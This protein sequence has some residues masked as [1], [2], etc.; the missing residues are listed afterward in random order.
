M[1][2][3]LLVSEVLTRV[4]NASSDDER[5]K[6]LKDFETHALLYVLRNSF[7]PQITFDEIG[8][9]EYNQSRQAIGLDF[10]SLHQE[11]RRIYVL[12][13]DF[14]K[15]TVARKR[16]IFLQILE[17]IHASEARLLEQVVKKEI[18]VK[19]LTP[20][21]VEKTFP[22]LLS[23]QGEVW[24]QK[25]HQTGLLKPTLKKESSGSKVGQD[26]SDPLGLGIND[27]KSETKPKRVSHSKSETP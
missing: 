22:G 13:D 9:P 8:V 11:A 2:K 3:N 17:A 25:A 24:T 27:M 21:L 16:E 23:W 1:R 4:N 6:I 12:A 7:T 14:K 18:K 5:I 10:S 20:E 15:I 26:I 19:G